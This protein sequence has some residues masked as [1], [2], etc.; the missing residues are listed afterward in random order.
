M[1]A[2]SLKAAKTSFYLSVKAA[3]GA[4][5]WLVGVKGGTLAKNSH[6]ALTGHAGIG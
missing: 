4:L 3:L 5:I 1:F 6:E 2:E